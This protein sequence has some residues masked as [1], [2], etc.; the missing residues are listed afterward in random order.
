MPDTCLPGFG[1]HLSTFLLLIDMSSTDQTDAS[2]PERVLRCSGLHVSH[3]G[4][5][6]LRGLDLEIIKGEV[7][8]VVVESELAARLIPR[9]FIGIE[10]AEAGEIEINGNVLNGL[11]ET[12]KLQLRRE[13][14]YLFH[15]SGLMSNLSVWY[16]V[17]LP[18]LYHTRFKDVQGVGEYVDV[19][20]NR[21]G[22]SG[23]SRLRPAALDESTKK[24]VA[25]ARAWVMSPG[26]LILED[27]LMDI[28][29]GSGGDLLD[30]AFG[31]SPDEWHD[32]DPR[33]SDPGVLITSQGLH[34][35]LFRYVD[36]MVIIS[37]GEKVFSGDPKK[38]DRR[39]KIY[40][41][42]LLNKREAS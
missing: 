19:L 30:L 25:L 13:V 28:D 17:A 11:S 21:C 4:E 27:P 42:D 22:L 37:K 3:D 16:N 34:E 32:R 10:S 7:V 8:A 33:P 2:Q 5:V 29:T 41:G 36:R 38:F 20:L 26:F 9:I 18:A 1:D 24:K 14:G 31:P 6:I 23:S 39:G 35:G 15:N 40:P 12:K